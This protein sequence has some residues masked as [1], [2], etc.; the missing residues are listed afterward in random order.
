MESQKYKKFIKL[1]PI[2]PNSLLS[3]TAQFIDQSCPDYLQ[4][5]NSLIKTLNNFIVPDVTSLYPS[6]PQ[7]NATNNI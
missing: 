4:T 6:I 3:H 2:Q 7:Q 1:P 5:S